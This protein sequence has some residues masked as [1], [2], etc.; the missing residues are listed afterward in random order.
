[1]IRNTLLP[2]L[3]DRSQEELLSWFM[4]WGTRPG[5]QGL[6]SWSAAVL[7]VDQC[8][9]MLQPGAGLHEDTSD[10]TVAV[11]VILSLAAG[12]C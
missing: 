4:W 6:A 2:Q 7:T 11:S 9:C 1:M 10:D 3:S 12:V 5:G 8:S